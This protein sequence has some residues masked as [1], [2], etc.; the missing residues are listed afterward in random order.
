[1]HEAKA[2]RLTDMKTKLSLVTFGCPPVIY[3]CLTPLL[4]QFWQRRGVESICL[5]IVN[6]NDPIA[7]LDRDYVRSLIKLYD[8]TESISLPVT[9]NYARPPWPLPA[10][11]L[12]HIGSIVILKEMEPNRKG[13]SVQAY[14]ISPEQLGNTVFCDLSMHPRTKYEEMLGYLE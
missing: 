10:P 14:N 8:S 2:Q 13:Q 4:D 9:I 7:R 11:N 5:A 12:Y 3:P 6:N 1:M